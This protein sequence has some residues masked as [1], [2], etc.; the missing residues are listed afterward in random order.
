MAAFQNFLPPSATVKRYGQQPMLINATELVPGDV[1]AVS[2][3][4]RIPADFVVCQEQAFEVDNSSL[5]GESEPQRR[6]ITNSEENPY[7]ATNL[8]FY[9]TYVV[10][11]TATG[12]VIR[13]GDCTLIGSI[14]S[15]MQHTLTVQTPISIEIQHFVHIITGVALLLGL[16]FLFIGVAEGYDPIYSLV[17]CIGIIVANVPE[18]LL[19]TVTAAL[20]LT[21][22]ELAK[23]NVLVKHLESVETL[24]S[25]SVIASDKT[26][27]LTMNA[28]TVH[29]VSY[30]NHTHLAV[31]SDSSDF[32]SEHNVSRL[33]VK[34][35]SFQRLLQV[36]ALCNNAKF[37]QQ[38]ENFPADQRK[39]L[40]DASE[41][42]LLKFCQKIQSV[43]ELRAQHPKITEIPFNS[44]N[45]YQLSIHLQDRKE[46]SPRLLAM[47]GVPERIIARCD[48]ILL[49]GMQTP[50]SPELVT[51]TEEEMHAM[52]D[53]GERVLGFCYCE[54]PSDRFPSNADF[55]ITD[56]Q[57]NFPTSKGEGLI[58]CGL[59]SM[60]DPPR[61]A[62]PHSVLLCQTAGIKVIMVTGDHPIT[63]QAIARQTYILRGKTKLDVWKDMKKE[64]VSD[65]DFPLSEVPSDHPDIQGIVVTGSEL[66]EM[67]PQELDEV[68]D[69]DQIVFARTNPS[70]KL[71][72]VQALQAKR[73][74]RRGYGSHPKP[75]KYIVAV[76][77]DGVNDAPALRAADIGV[78]MGKGGSDVAREAADMVL[79]DDDFSSVVKG[80]E[81]GRLI[82]DNLKKSIAYTLTSN[83]PEISPFLM[84]VLLQMPLALPTA[85][86]LLIDLVT[87][88]VPAISLAYEQ[89]EANIMSKPP[90][91][92]TTDRLVTNKLVNY[93]Y[94][95]IGV[96]QS[97]M[98]FVVYFSVLKDYGFP[99]HMVLGAAQDWENKNLVW[100][101]QN[102]SM[103]VPPIDKSSAFTECAPFLFLPVT[104]Q[105][106]E[107][108]T[109][110]TSCNIDKGAYCP[111]LLDCKNP[112]LNPEEALSHAQTSF[113]LAIIMSQWATLLVC[114]TRVLSLFTHGMRN[115]LLNIS[116]LLTFSISLILI[117]LPICN[118]SL[119]TRPIHF[120]HWFLPLPMVVFIFCY[121]EIRKYAL[122]TLQPENWVEVYT[123]Y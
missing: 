45:K 110:L 102:G 6:T 109:L 118:R 63:A 106:G 24:G 75:I 62:V 43:E 120:T 80:V 100:L 49:N 9:G 123:Y 101:A 2:P 90:R 88:M 83:V 78:A 84:F 94:L 39:T 74:I 70:Q 14:A 38:D 96:M 51:Q 81:Q 61:P 85:L 79:L 25:T 93:A 107:D 73:F 10:K 108:K 33:D 95:Q 92:V 91:N 71:L 41:T 60:M 97:M 55:Y 89:K 121:D 64:N 4:E 47:K 66:A 57:P 42:A 105:G 104:G 103:C 48:N 20:T 23:K 99:S 116:L 31:L 16:S 98:G 77:G 1:I 54:L 56:D 50:F 17:F 18:G 27:T 32:D 36:A 65:G 114:K 52:M 112:C 46:T 111:T 29:H 69:Y 122:R 26:G 5:T 34:N 86:I 59:I 82:F 8:A 22:K 76:T 40:G 15:L 35:P 72:I 28:M 13:T 58:F 87:D 7:E 11:G 68:L 67:T 113:F 53:G 3:G 37:Q 21:A 117:Y 30:E 115:N 12:I 19:A 44:S 119:G